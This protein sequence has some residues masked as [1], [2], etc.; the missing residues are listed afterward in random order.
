MKDIRRH[1]SRVFE[2]AWT[3]TM[4]ELD[5]F[6]LTIEPT[7]MWI[8]CGAEVFVAE[9]ATM[10]RHSMHDAIGTIELTAAGDCS[11]SMWW[12]DLRSRTSSRQVQRTLSLRVSLL[13][14]A[15]TVS[16]GKFRSLA[17]IRSTR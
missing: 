12:H 10:W 1:I 16:V 8:S 15:G 7:H 9:E 13:D 2:V 5:L 14:T 17:R 3:E 4:W 11:R 6:T